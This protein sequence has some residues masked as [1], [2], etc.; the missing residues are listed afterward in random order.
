MIYPSDLLCS[1]VSRCPFGGARGISGAAT[2]AA[3]TAAPRCALRGPAPLA[4]ARTSLWHLAVFKASAVRLPPPDLLTGSLA[5]AERGDAPA[6]SLLQEPARRRHC[7]CPPCGP[8]TPVWRCCPAPCN[9]AGVCEGTGR[10]PPAAQVGIMA[11]E[12]VILNVYDMVSVHSPPTKLH[13]AIRHQLVGGGGGGSER[14]TMNSSTPVPPV[15]LTAG[16]IFAKS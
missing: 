12:P 16:F 6:P 7:R 5:P 15:H 9:A 8:V 10:S 14:T 2:W 3:S 11:S 1:L 13:F 4:F